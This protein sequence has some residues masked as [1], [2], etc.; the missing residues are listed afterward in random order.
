[1]SEDN[2]IDTIVSVGIAIIGGL[3]STYLTKKLFDALDNNKKVNAN[4]WI[5]ILKEA[6]A[7]KK[8]Y[9]EWQ[10]KF[11]QRTGHPLEISNSV[12]II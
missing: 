9:E 7:A 6:D 1:M 3:I 5:I 2:R 8:S 10:K 12:R 11:E 4:R